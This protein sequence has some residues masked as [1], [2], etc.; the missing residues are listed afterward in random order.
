MRITPSLILAFVALS[1]CVITQAQRPFPI[2]RLTSQSHAFK[3][4]SD[5]GPS[6]T[7]TYIFQEGGGHTA[8]GSGMFVEHTIV[9][10]ERSGKLIA[11][12][13]ANGYQTSRSLRCS[14]KTE[15]NKISLYLQ[16]YREDNTFELYKKGQLLLTL[17]RSIV[18]GRARILTYWGAYQSAFRTL[19]SGRVYFRKTK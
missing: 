4:Q 16:S 19:R 15:G 12:I 6:W 11:D 3:N 8:G 1:L 13:D 10:Y 14:T 17:E 7:G 5:Q 9:I 2:S 18:G